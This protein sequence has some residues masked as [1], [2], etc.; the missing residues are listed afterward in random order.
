MSFAIMRRR[1]SRASFCRL[2]GGVLHMTDE[3]LGNEY[4]HLIRTWKTRAAAK[5]VITRII[6]RY[7][8]PSEFGVITDYSIVER[9]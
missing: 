4:P 5:G 6:R 1:G 8:P 9:S 2:G 7:E 3:K